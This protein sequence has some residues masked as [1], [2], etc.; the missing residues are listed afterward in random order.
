MGDMKSLRW[1]FI[2]LIG[3]VGFGMSGCLDTGVDFDPNEQMA[4]D[5]ETIDQYLAQKNIDAI[6]DMSGLRFHLETV[7]TGFPPRFDQTVKVDY[8][9]KFLSGVSFDDGV[10]ESGVLKGYI[11]GWQLALSVWPAG[12]KGTVYIPSPLAYGNQAVGS[13]P[14]NTI[15]VFDIHLKEVVSSSAEKARLAQDIVTIDEY[16]ATNS[17]DAVKDSTG[18]RYVITNPGTGSLPTWYTKVKF[19]YTGRV[20]LTNAQFFDGTSQPD[21]GFDSRMIDFINGIKVGLS[22][23]GAGGKITIYVPSGLAFG[24]SESTQSPVPA[25]S[26]VVYEIEVVE[27]L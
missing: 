7:G 2:V 25:N 18:V 19:N 8:T 17:I 9:G 21:A 16:L 15:L 27:L 12:T 10:D 20:M 26:N 14:P 13:I 11:A 5:I 23:V 6:V 22:K 1:S 4:A 3:L 24:P